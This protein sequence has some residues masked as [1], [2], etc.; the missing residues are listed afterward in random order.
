MLRLLVRLLT[1]PAALALALTS[2]GCGVAPAEDNSAVAVPTAIG[3]SPE[4]FLGTTECDP[5]AGDARSYVATI[6]DQ[7]ICPEG[8][9]ACSESGQCCSGVCTIPAGMK[10][11]DKD[12][13]PTGTCAAKTTPTILPSSPPLRCNESVYFRGVIVG[14]AYS[15]QVDVYDV[16]ASE[17]VPA[18]SPLGSEPGQWTGARQMLAAGTLAPLA[19]TLETQC[20]AEPALRAVAVSSRAVFVDACEALG[21]PAATP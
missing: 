18:A 21:A 4:D 5:L 11:T 12:G 15:A 20:G 10:G 6:V 17:L 13:Q 16:A 1:G 19:P 9:Q 14:H 3:L 2:A 7:T 8:E